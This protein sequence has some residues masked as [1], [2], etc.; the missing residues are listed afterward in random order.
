[1]RALYFGDSL[2]ETVAVRSGKPLRITR[3]LERFES[4]ARVLGYPRAEIE[5]G[6]EAL[7]Q[8]QGE[9][10]LY[11]LTF[12]RS[13]SVFGQWDASILTSFRPFPSTKR[14]TLTI[15][16]T[17]LPEDS[18][19]EHK[20]CSYLRPMHVRRTAMRAGFDDAIQ[21]SP[22]GLVGEASMA[23]VFVVA[24]GHILTPRAR[25]ILAGTVRAEL[26]ERAR[27]FDLKISEA[28]VSLQQLNQADEVILTS[29]GVGVLAAA[30]FAGRNLG[31]S[32]ATRLGDLLCA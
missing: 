24:D 32:V 13:S 27:D 30:S 25:G 28:E 22:G 12:I 26:L 5:S 31:D 18:F 7:S 10:G 9:D 1:M 8:I 16:R 15:A 20:T 23:N 17:Y 29:A 3:H 2:F 4:S 6:L 14:P 11:R 19:A 21:V